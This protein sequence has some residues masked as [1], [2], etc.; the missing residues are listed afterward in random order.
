MA[1]NNV[2]ALPDAEMRR[3]MNGAG[4]G[5][6]WGLPIEGPEQLEKVRY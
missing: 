6:N 1:F 2:V 5:K 4:L 3:E